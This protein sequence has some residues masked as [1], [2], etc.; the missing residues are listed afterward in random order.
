MLHGKLLFAVRAQTHSPCAANH[1]DG[2]LGQYPDT[3]EA[4]RATPTPTAG[5]LVSVR[6][7]VYPNIGRTSSQRSAFFQLVEKFCV[8]YLS[9]ATST[10]CPRYM[11]SGRP[12]PPTGGI[13]AIGKSERA[14]YFSESPNQPTKKRFFTQ[15]RG[16]HESPR[17]TAW[18]PGGKISPLH[19]PAGRQVPKSCS[20]PRRFFAAFVP[21]PAGQKDARRQFPGIE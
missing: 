2:P 3:T 5:F 15:Y 20:L 18:D 21:G 19:L 12:Q 11:G 13:F 9:D 10:A 16:V 14:D 6:I 7:I 17:R 4:K 8:R 1:D